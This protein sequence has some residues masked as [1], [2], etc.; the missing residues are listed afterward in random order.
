M[1]SL[2]PIN[3]STERLES[4]LLGLAKLTDP[5]SPGW[6]RE[7]FTE[8]YRESRMWIE[9]KMRAAG[10][11]VS[12]D[13]AGN[14]VGLLPG[15]APTAAPIVTGSHT[16]TVR[17]GGRFD[18]IVGVLGAIEL[19]RCYRE[20]GVK[21]THDLVVVDFLGEESNDYGLSCLGSR[22][23]TADMSPSDF[24]RIDQR[25]IPLATRYEGFGLVKSAAVVYDV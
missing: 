14:V 6:S 17:G 15:L 12:R 20:S 9:K 18:G 22:A 23:L 10:L 11:E 25:G 21:L 3:P 4:D 13:G 19:A 7:V 2:S 1:T 24:A 8:P 16:D 5:D